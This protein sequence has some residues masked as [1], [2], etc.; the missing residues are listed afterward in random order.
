MSA[1]PQKG[2]GISFWRRKTGNLYPMRA[3]DSRT[4]FASFGAIL[5]LLLLLT[6]FSYRNFQLLAQA[7][8]ASIQTYQVLLQ[9]SNLLRSLVDMDTGLRGYIVVGD[10]R[11]LEPFNTGQGDF[12]RTWNE[13]KR[14]T[15]EHP[16]HTQDLRQLHEEEQSW[17]KDLVMPLIAARRGAHNPSEVMRLSFP[18]ALKRKKAMDS[19]R[20]CITRI[21]KREDVFLRGRT[22]EQKE[23]QFWTALTLSLGSIFSIVATIAL[24]AF[25]V[26]NQRHLARTVQQ[27]NVAKSSLEDEVRERRRTEERLAVMNEDLKRSNDELEQFA[28]VA[29][30]DLQEPLRAVGGCVQV[31]QRR[32]TGKLD[33]RADQFIQHAVEGATRMQALIN[34]LLTYSRTGSRPQVFAPADLDEVLRG[35]E[36][37][38]SVA[39]QES[40]AQLTHYAL[41]EVWCDASQIALVL[42]NFV[43]NAIKFRGPEP[44][45]IHISAREDKRLGEWVISVTDKGIGI[46]PEY[47]DR[48]WVMFQRLH[49]RETYAGTG[50]GLA[51]CKK[52]IERHGGRIGVEST[53]GEGSTFWFSLPSGPRTSPSPESGEKI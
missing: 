40:G 47:F 36:I 46:E 4:L 51:I 52:I 14:I 16:E 15:A 2:G 26:R 6:G 39:I 50:I 5:A 37:M 1:A 53:P 22:E 28:Y 32:Y 10:D 35:V 18:T 45:Q 7:D 13:V 19:M 42:Q 48:I 24:A 27:L 34:D 23:L 41:P 30:H 31:L 44:P 49:T 12:E 29:S 25:A 8:R 38:L 9:T 43:A 33:A 17:V 21:E 11:F 20:A 3:N